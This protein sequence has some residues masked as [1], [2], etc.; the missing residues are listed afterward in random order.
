MLALPVS[1]AAR[2]N[3]ARPRIA[4]KG[5]VSAKNA[6][7]GNAGRCRTIP[8]APEATLGFVAT[9]NAWP[10][11]S[12][13]RRKRRAEKC[14]V[15]RAKPAPGSYSARPAVPRHV[16]AVAPVAGKE[17]NVATGSARPSRSVV[18]RSAIAAASAVMKTRCAA[19]ARVPRPA[20]ARRL[21]SLAPIP[22]F[23]AR[24]GRHASRIRLT[25]QKSVVGREV[26]AANGVAGAAKHVMRRLT[27]WS[28]F[29]VPMRGLPMIR[30]FV[31]C[32]VRSSSKQ[33]IG[34]DVSSA[35]A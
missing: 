21:S 23:A 26:H 27:T 4:K 8:R 19:R 22:T 32:R 31:A 13:V 25:S 29:A 20:T 24:K 28:R 30:I 18:Q 9:A 10:K 1:S 11:Q 33:R 14:V 3:A 15:H 12:A 5:A 2:S 35:P 6:G 17:S 34:R 16:N 7:A